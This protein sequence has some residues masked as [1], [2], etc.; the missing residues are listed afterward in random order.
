MLE[1]AIDAYLESVSERAFDEPL[2]ALLRSQEFTDVHLVHGRAEFGK[3]VIA[4]RDGQQWA[5]Q[6]KAGD[7]RQ[8]DWREL[9]GQLDE[10]RRNNLSHP[11]FN[12]GLERCCVLV[13]TGRLTGNAPVSAQEYDRWAR[14]HGEP[15]LTV[16]DRDDL[17]TMLLESPTAVLRGSSDGELLSMLGT[18][19]ERALSM[20][21]IREF[22]KRWA[23]WNHARLASLGIVELGLVAQALVTAE[24]RD[25]A[26]H[27]TLAM[28]L[29]AWAAG[30]TEHGVEI[31]ADAAGGMFESYAMPLFELRNNGLVDPLNGLLVQPPFD[32]ASYPVR[33]IRTAELLSLLA[34]RLSDRDESSAYEI[35]NLVAQL[36][37][38]HPGCAHPL[39]DR[40][41]TSLIP[42]VLVLQARHRDLATKLL[43]EAARWMANHYSS[44][45]GLA[46]EDAAPEEEVM[47]AFGAG[48]RH[49]QQLRRR[50][51]S[52]LAG[53]LTDLAAVLALEELYNDIR[54]DTIVVGAVPIL[55]L[56][57]TADA[58]YRRFGDGVRRLMPAYADEWPG[59]GTPVAEHH[60]DS[61]ARVE[62]R[63]SARY[64]DQFA[65]QAVLRDR[66]G[67]EALRRVLRQ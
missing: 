30:D 57:D 53:V 34:L 38:T 61:A 67:I 14:D 62:V 63:R 31:V 33:A 4:K 39:S 12:T 16:W 42:I 22:A 8:S 10:L 40:Y 56:A 7:M 23:G 48:L 46:A 2:L 28:V 27:C 25:L 26:C 58:Q 60:T 6:S 55:T 15:G 51:E 37:D 44:P 66:H 24:R 41:A 20:D 45:L 59:N 64:W 21:R 36:V 5:F 13:C 29:A 32:W 19:E 50:R 47:R 52:Y 9:T 11:S 3:D 43:R 18:I 1:D 49:V 65:V 17:R 54:N 35:C